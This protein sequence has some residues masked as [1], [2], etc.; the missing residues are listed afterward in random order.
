[1]ENIG[2]LVPFM[3]MAIPIA[4]VWIV[5]Y[6]DG[7]IKEQFHVT[8][9][10][11]IA[12]GQELTPEL[13]ASVPGYKPGKR[14]KDDIRT[15]VIVSGIGIGIAV[16]GKVG[17]RSEEVVGMGLLVACIGLGFLAYGIYNKKNSKSN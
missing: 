1:M 10:K 2:E 12:S 9:Q 14:I 11:L 16:F 5:F 3:G 4:I 8:L 13:L 17:I 15:G 7:Q 6:Y